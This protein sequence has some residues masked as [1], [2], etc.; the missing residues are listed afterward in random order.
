MNC[1][2]VETRSQPQS[3]SSRVSAPLSG[4]ARRTASQH[5]ARTRA[6]CH[7]T[8]VWASLLLLLNP[9]APIGGRQCQIQVG[10]PDVR[11]THARRV[12]GRGN[13]VQRMEQVP[14]LRTV[15]FRK[16]EL[17][18]EQ[19]HGFNATPQTAVA[20]I[21]VNSRSRASRD[22]CPRCR[23]RWAAGWARWCLDAACSG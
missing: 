8:P 11:A 20:G 4:Q 6:L 17:L 10:S 23:S 3:W 16:S 9:G 7:W 1:C 5:W 15:R 18:F 13:S 2:R 21:S 19:V 12:L 14:T 22:T